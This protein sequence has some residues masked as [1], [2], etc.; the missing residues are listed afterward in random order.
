MVTM[1]G[2]SERFG[3]AFGGPNRLGIR[4]QLPALFKKHLR[5]IQVVSLVRVKGTGL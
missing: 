4:G 1:T 2:S 5:H 3:A